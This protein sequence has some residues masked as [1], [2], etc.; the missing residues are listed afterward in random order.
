MMV[1]TISMNS[2]YFDEKDVSK[3]L[4]LD[5]VKNLFAV[6]A[7]S[8][9]LI[10]DVHM[11][12]EDSA[13]IVEWVQTSIHDDCP[14]KFQLITCD[15]VVMLEKIFP[16]NHYEYC[17][18]EEDYQERLAEWLEENPGWER[19]SY[20]TWINVIEN[21]RIRKQIEENKEK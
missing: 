7:K 3:N 11:Y 15:Q 10:V 1:V 5:F 6:A 16:D 14:D 12:M 4:H 2:M 8:E 19:T 20:G 9:H 17:T 21:E 13:I 18:S